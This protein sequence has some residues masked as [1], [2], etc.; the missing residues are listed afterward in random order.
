MICLNDRFDYFHLMPR[1]YFAGTSGIIAVIF[2]CKMLKSLFT[3][4]YYG[5]IW[6]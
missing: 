3:A 2:C 5:K 4:I 6:A 1:F